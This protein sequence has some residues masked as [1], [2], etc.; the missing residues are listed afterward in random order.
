[1]HRSILLVLTI[2]ALALPGCA[3]RSPLPLA[4]LS[5]GRLRLGQAPTSDAPEQ[6]RSLLD[7]P[8]RYK[9]PTSIALAHT[10]ADY[11]GYARIVG[12]ED[13]ERW[14]AIAKGC[15]GITGF[16]PVTPMLVGTDSPSLDDLRV[17]ADAM[18]CE[19]LMVVGTAQSQVTNYTDAA[20]LYWT[21]VGLWL[22]PGHSVEHK[23]LMQAMLVDVRTGSV[24]CVA[25][26][27]AYA[28][29]L[30]ASAY[31]EI[32]QDKVAK[33][34]QKQAADNLFADV[35]RLLKALPAPV[36]AAADN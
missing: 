7:T 1:M 31:K 22:A 24:L 3:T 2:L 23:T 29:Q 25:T 17:A 32:A 34:T 9:L 14:T 35:E 6:H 8:P 30:T 13:M 5:W 33:Q 11:R 27:E 26:G 10:Y 36:A 18:R 19:L 21:F 20:G 16:T 4:E 28:K 12:S 15:P